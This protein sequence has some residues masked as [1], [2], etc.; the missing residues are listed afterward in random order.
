MYVSCMLL[1]ICSKY[2]LSN[3]SFVIPR[4]SKLKYSSS[5]CTLHF[6][7]IITKWI[8]EHSFRSTLIFSSMF[9]H[10]QQRSCRR[11]VID[12]MNPCSVYVVLVKQPFHI[13]YVLFKNNYSKSCKI[14]IMEWYGTK[15]LSITDNYSNLSL[16][17]DFK[18]VT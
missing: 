15:Y 18:N 14:N 17:L 6:I 9:Y 12:H 11:I 2:H 4:N 3:S 1:I 13:H 7:D 8:H 10:L 16:S 5:C